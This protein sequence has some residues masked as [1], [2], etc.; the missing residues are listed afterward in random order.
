[1]GYFNMEVAHISRRVQRLAFVTQR[2]GYTH[3][4][5]VRPIPMQSRPIQGSKIESACPGPNT[6]RRARPPQVRGALARPA[7]LGRLLGAPRVVLCVAPAGYGKTTALAAHLAELGPACWYALDADD[8]DP[9]TLAGGLAAAVARLPG[10]ERVARA[11]DEG[12]SPRAAARL[13]ADALDGHGALLV[14]D[15]AQHLAHPLAAEVA[16]ELLSGPRVALLSRTPLNLPALTVAEARGELL[17]LGTVELSFDL[18][19]I[20]ALFVMAG[21]RLTPTEA[22]RALTVT[23][24]WPIAARFLA[25]AVGGGQLHLGALRDLEAQSTQLGALFAFLAQEVLGPLDP[26]LHTLLRRSSVF[27]SLTPELL[28]DVLNEG[29]AGAYLET[30]AR[31]GTFLTREGE[32]YRAHPLLRAHLRGS[33]ETDEARD[34]ARRGAAHFE[35]V[36]APRLALQAHLHS[37]DARRAASLLARHGGSWLSQGRLTLLERVFEQLPTAALAGRPELFALLGDLLRAQSRY[38]QAHAAYAHAPE[39][40]R[41]LGQARAYLDTVEPAAAEPLLARAEQLEGRD[42]LARLRA[43]ND[44]NSGR[45]EEAA[46]RWPDLTLGARFALR[47]GDLRGALTR[48]RLGARGELGEARPARNHREGLLLESLLCTFLGELAEALSSARL[49]LAEGERLESPFVQS[50]A[51]ARLG[52]AHLAGGAWP[53]AHAEYDQA[54][55]LAEELGA[56]RLRV[57][58]LMGLAFL[59]AARGHA[60]AQDV[61]RQALDICAASGDPYMGAL[62]RLTFALGLIH[63]GHAGAAKE[64]ERAGTAFRAVGDAH[65]AAGADLALFA[66]GGGDSGAAAHALGAYPE[67]LSAP[68]LFAPARARAGRAAVLARLARALPGRAAAWQTVAGALGYP[69]VPREHPGAEVRVRLLGRLALT[70]GDVEVSDWGR[71]KAREL[72]ALL[73]VRLEGVSR[74]AAQEALYPDAPPGVGERNLRVVLHALGQVLEAGGP[75]GYFLERGEWLRLR[76]SPDLTVDWRGAWNALGARPGTPG[77]AEALLALPAAMASVA[78]PEL[79]AE[80]RRYAARLPDALAEEAAWALPAGEPD[81]A[82]RLAG[83]TLELEGAHEEAAR[84]LMRAQHARLGAA[85][86]AR[87]YRSCEV[88]L[89][90]L[91]LTP[92]METRLLYRALTGD[93]NLR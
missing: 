10:G 72:L 42:A 1:M 66:L 3:Q 48:A 39:S 15:E 27:E 36:G 63:A 13:T 2:H 57:E 17:R 52:H 46:A 80:A 90:Q 23:E 58:P 83:R 59:A 71:A 34:L 8:A 93:T 5:L 18:A 44:L 89:A 25:Q 11:L 33:L 6:P 67:L 79:E 35:K 30:L 40:A 47:S 77:R 45:L 61:A 32:S 20:Q 53:A 78:L 91:G 56:P 70:R 7:L 54:L 65:G 49:G 12:A 85:G 22:R 51:R 26:A 29:R 55:N 87:V 74:E 60:G 86:V 16:A 9:A 43:E 69:E 14:L 82:A 81:A 38:P 31:G 37:G 19:E 76:P 92:T 73:A 84:T 41:V 75:G 4:G 88:A 21:A 50:L 62:V 28:A 24:G 64:L 68:A